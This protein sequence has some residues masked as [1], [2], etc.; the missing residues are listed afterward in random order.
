[1][2]ST[3]APIIPIFSL[4]IF[5]LGYY[6]FHASDSRPSIFYLMHKTKYTHKIRI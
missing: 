4:G 3:P 6:L 2:E 1:M 5:N